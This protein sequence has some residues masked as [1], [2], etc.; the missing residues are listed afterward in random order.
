MPTPADR[1]AQDDLAALLRAHRVGHLA[2]ADAAGAPHLVPVCFAYDGQAVYTAIDH[3]P[4]RQ[5]GYRMKRIRN[6]LANAQVAFLIDRYDEDW[7]QLYYV[8]MR[9]TATILER[10][11]ERHHALT[12]LEDKYPQY[13]ERHLADGTGLVVKIV[14]V[15][16]QQWSW[17]GGATAP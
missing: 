13:R 16:V 4:K 14:P 1:P 10:G 8:M 2:T 5:T 15:S 12:L 7:Q 17:Q 3:K 6:I 9:G 11:A